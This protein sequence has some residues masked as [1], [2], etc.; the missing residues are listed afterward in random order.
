MLQDP[1]RESWQLRF[2]RRAVEL[3]GPLA[4]TAL[5]IA[6]AG[7]LLGWD[8]SELPLV[9]LTLPFSAVLFL[10]FPPPVVT[11]VVC[12]VLAATIWASL[13]G[14]RAGLSDGLV[15]WMVV[16]WVVASTFSALLFVRSPWFGP[17]P[18]LREAV[19][20]YAVP[21]GFEEVTRSEAGTEACFLSCTE[22]QIA[23][24]LKT[25]LPPAEACRAIEASIRTVARSVGPPPSHVVQPPAAACFFRG[26]LP[27]I[28]P[29]A[30]LIAIVMSGPELANHFWLLADADPESFVRDG[31]VVALLFNSPND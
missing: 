14:S 28:H 1:G 29:R 17:W 5:V 3:Y 8:F 18:R 24:V 27:Q 22:P 30:R 20:S 7:R 25:T 6:V 15:A 23:V 2:V 13:R 16:L 31:T 4:G 11:I 10:A 21:P 12:S 19:A 9:I 26:D